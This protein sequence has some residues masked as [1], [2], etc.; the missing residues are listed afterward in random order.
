[1]TYTDEA[2]NKKFSIFT[3]WDWETKTDIRLSNDN[4]HWVK[5]SCKI[6]D[7]FDTE[8]RSILLFMKFLNRLMRHTDEVVLFISFDIVRL[9]FVFNNKHITGRIIFLV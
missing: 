7:M 4:K 6:A 3:W 9:C 1:M 5:A 2:K 8:C